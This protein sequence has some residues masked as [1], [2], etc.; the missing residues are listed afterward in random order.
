MMYTFIATR[1]NQNKKYHKNNDI[2]DSY[3]L[4][5]VQIDYDNLVKVI[6]TRDHNF[7]DIHDIYDII[8]TKSLLKSKN[9]II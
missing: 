2:Q 8:P 4:I 6:V 9:K 7:I 1:C 3:D 5:I